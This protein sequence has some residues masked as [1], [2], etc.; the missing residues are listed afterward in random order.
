[1]KNKTIGLVFFGIA[2]TGIVGSLLFYWHKNIKFKDAK[3][4]RNIKVVNKRN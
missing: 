2:I 4:N 1:M 3:K